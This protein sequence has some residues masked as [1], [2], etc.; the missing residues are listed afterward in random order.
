[1]TSNQYR[2]NTGAIPGQE[3]LGADAPEI[4]GATGQVIDEGA[5]IVARIL[6]ET[7]EGLTLHVPQEDWDALL[8]A[9]PRAGG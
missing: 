4:L 1:M 8:D 5:I 3:V 6:A 7:E 9:L 2:D